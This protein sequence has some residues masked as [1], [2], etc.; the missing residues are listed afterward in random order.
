MP[1]SDGQKQ[2]RRKRDILKFLTSCDTPSSQLVEEEQGDGT[3][4]SPGEAA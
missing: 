4:C 1:W 2:E 3:V